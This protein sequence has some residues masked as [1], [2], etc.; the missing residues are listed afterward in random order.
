MIEQVNR[1]QADVL[2]VGLT[3]PKQ[4]KWVAE[5]HEKLNV[6]QICSVGAVF[7]FFAGDVKRAGDF[8][9]KLNLEWFIRLVKEPR[10][11]WRRYLV[12]GPLFFFYLLLYLLKIKK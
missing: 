6:R 3:A 7:N 11:M 10:R 9:L 2:F 8:W 5:V 4:E 1:F 12:H